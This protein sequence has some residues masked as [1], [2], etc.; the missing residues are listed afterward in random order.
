MHL[1]LSG[2]GG[3]DDSEKLDKKFV[4][5]LDS[6]KPL[7]YI[8]I[9]MDA[10]EH[11]YANCFDWFKN[12]MVPYG[13]EN[14]TMWTG[15]DLINK[16][17]TD[18]QKFCGIYIGGGNTFKLL[19]ELKELGAFD[20]LKNLAQKDM[21]IYGG[22]AGAIIFGKT[23]II[24]TPMDDNSLIGLK[25]FSAMNLIGGCDLWCHYD[26]KQ[27]EMIRKCIVEYNLNKVIAIPENS[28]AL[29]AESEI[30]VIGFSSI[31]I[32]TKNDCQEFAPG[33]KIS[34]NY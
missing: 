27:D 10:S 16:D 7:L 29:M 17:E 28:G 1:F 14:I 2:G 21:P 6:T 31:K 4:E 19:K 32:F 13:I 18:F 20:I 22:S 12:V 3:K 11:P 25:D 33:D 23:I 9:A 26:A 15:E 8:P 34:L 24:A 30:E 5:S